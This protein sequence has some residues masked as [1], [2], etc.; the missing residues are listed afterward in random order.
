MHE[1]MCERMHTHPYIKEFNNILPTWGQALF[2]DTHILN[3]SREIGATW[4]QPFFRDTYHARSKAMRQNMC[5]QMYTHRY[6]Q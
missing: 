3:N 5:G 4:G 1:H 6:I 2:R